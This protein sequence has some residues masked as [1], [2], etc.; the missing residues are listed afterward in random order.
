MAKKSPAGK[1]RV[2]PRVIDRIPKCC[3]QPRSPGGPKRRTDFSFFVRSTSSASSSL[4]NGFLG[5]GLLLESLCKKNKLINVDITGLEAMTDDRKEIS[6]FP[7]TYCRNS[8]DK[9]RHLFANVTEVPTVEVESV[10]QN[11]LFEAWSDRSVDK[12]NDDMQRKQKFVPDISQVA[13][14]SDTCINPG[15]IVWAKTSCQQ[16]WPAEVVEGTSTKVDSGDQGIHQHVLIQ[17]CGKQESAWVDPARD[18]SPFDD[19]FEERISNQLEEFQDALKL[20]LHKKECHLSK[21][22][23]ES[24]NDFDST[25]QHDQSHDLWNSSSSSRADSPGKEQRRGK[26]MRKPKVHFD[27]VPHSLKSV[28]RVRRFR[29]MRSLGLAAPVGSPFSLTR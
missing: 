28:R 7:L 4:S 22:S 16:W 11:A 25:S 10:A 21:L 20:A 19:C 6:K 5:K 2:Q 1:K 9:R 14:S 18:L 24:S 23:C 26:R 15:S 27:E 29:I 12:Q 13:E 8:K 17:Y 3:Q